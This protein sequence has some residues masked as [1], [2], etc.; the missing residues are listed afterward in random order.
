MEDWDYLSVKYYWNKIDTDGLGK[1]NNY[2]QES[3]KLWQQ[4]WGLGMMEMK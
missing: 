4:N 2:P 3:I 1:P